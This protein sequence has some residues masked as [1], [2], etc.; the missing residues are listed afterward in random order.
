MV[1]L[2]FASMAYTLMAA[3]RR[4]GLK[5]TDMARAQCGTIR[6]RLLKIGA[7]IWRNTRRIRLALA[8]HHPMREVY[9]LAAQRLA[10]IP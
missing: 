4:I 3:L 5:G 8:S 1:K 10:A 9:R 2:S 6:L 7:Q